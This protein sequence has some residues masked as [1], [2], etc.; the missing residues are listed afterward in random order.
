MCIRDRTTPTQP[1]RHPRGYR[2]WGKQTRGSGPQTDAHTDSRELELDRSA[3]ITRVEGTARNYC[4]WTVARP[5]RG[6]R[7]VMCGGLSRSLEG[8]LLAPDLYVVLPGL[9]RYQE[10]AE[11]TIHLRPR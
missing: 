9:G 2:L 7:E 1:A 4:I 8:E 6:A 10:S 3:V 11:V 5:G